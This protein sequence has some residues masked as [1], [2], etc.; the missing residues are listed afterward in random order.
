[1]AQNARLK[2]NQP[3]ETRFISSPLSPDEQNDFAAADIEPL[4]A[5]AEA[6]AAM[7]ANSSLKTLAYVFCNPISFARDAKY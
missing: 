3:W 7:L 2:K 1:M 6:Q 5:S 4:R